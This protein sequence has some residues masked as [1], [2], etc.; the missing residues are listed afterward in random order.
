M[1]THKESPKIPLAV[2]LILLIF[3]YRA[4]SLVGSGIIDP[5]YYWHI[6]YGEWIIENGALPSKDFW[7]WTFEGHPYRLTQWLGEVVMGW[8]NKVAGMRGTAMMAAFLSTSTIY[9][10]YLSARCFIENKIAALI[11]AVF[12]NA[13]LV[14]LPARP[15]QFTHLGLAYFSFVFS[16]YFYCGIKRW[17]ITIPLVM[18]LWVNLHGGYVVGV[19]YLF[20]C[21]GLAL[22]NCYFEGC[23][24]NKRSAVKLTAFIC[25]LTLLA[26]LVNPYGLGAWAYVVEIVGLKSSSAGIVDEWSATT[27]KTDVGFHYFSVCFAVLISMATSS[28]RPKMSEIV[29]VV[30]VC[31]AGMSSLRMSLMATIMV[32]PMLAI[33]FRRTPLYTL[34]FDKNFSK[35]DRS[36]GI[37]P[38]LLI[39]LV[40]LIGGSFYALID[41]QTLRIVEKKFPVKEVEFLKKHEIKGKILNTP[42]TGGYLIRKL[43]QP[44]SIDT[45]LDLYKDK[46]LF[47]LLFALRG[48]DN[49]EKYIDT[50]M[51]SIIILN[52]AHALKRLLILS[53]KYRLVFEGENYSILLESSFRQ[54]VSAIKPAEKTSVFLRML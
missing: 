3:F 45:R 21:S 20:F 40:V 12:C 50:S 15:H 42:E 7:S 14:S 11:V 37:L 31:I 22:L 29:Y 47:E 46:A 23:L 16:S 43:N 51:A 6:S 44:V 4:P 34:V 35:F 38:A 54:D 25:L 2:F 26:T 5:D 30:L 27:I 1:E 39:Y 10:S 33:F 28:N 36:V 18:V 52:N 24:N 49:W 19:G 17:L 13:I 41:N 8:L 32:A 9:F 48:E 53:N